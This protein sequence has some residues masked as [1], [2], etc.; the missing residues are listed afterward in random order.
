MTTSQPAT[1]SA[2]RPS[3]ARAASGLITGVVGLLGLTTI[4]GG[5]WAFTDPPS[6][7]RWVQFPVHHHFL[8]DIGAFQIGIGVTLLLALLWRDGIAVGLGGFFTSNTLHAFS[9]LMD[10]DLGGRATDWL[11]IGALSVVALITLLARLRQ[12]ATKPNLDPIG[13]PR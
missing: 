1:M 13:D 8:H 2:K 5:I 7:A 9:H 4:A 3:S 11:L 6:F 12:T 10:V